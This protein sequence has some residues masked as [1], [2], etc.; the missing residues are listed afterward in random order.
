MAERPIYIPKYEAG[1]LVETKYIDFEWFSGLAPIQKQ[2][3]IQS[4]HQSAKSCGI[5]KHPLEVSSKSIEPLGVKLSAFNLKVKTEKYNREFT[6]ESAYQSSKIF[7]NGGPYKDLLYGPSLAAKKDPRLKDSGPIIG[8]EFFGVNW[9][10]EPRTAFY[11]WLYINALKK[12]PDA[13]EALGNFDAFTDIEFN[14]K[15]SLNCQAYSVALFKSL[16]GRGLLA[17]ALVSKEAFLD[18]IGNRPVNTANE[19]T[20][21]QS[22]LL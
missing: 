5:S 15:K 19:N 12:N 16:Q 3:S 1:L 8:F 17:D 7:Q 22:R 13:V 6:V 14:P 18:V 4:L 2:K 20:L 21:T 10:L 9:S 11:D